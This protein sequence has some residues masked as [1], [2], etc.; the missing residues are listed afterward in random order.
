M[1]IAIHRTHDSHHPALRTIL[2]RFPM[3]PASAAKQGPATMAQ[4][5]QRAGAASRTKESTGSGSEEM[6]NSSGCDCDTC[7]TSPPPSSVAG[8][9]TVC[10]VCRLTTGGPLV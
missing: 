4:L 7:D 9:A 8:L 5:T 3:Q 2:R 6:G 1:T 10:D